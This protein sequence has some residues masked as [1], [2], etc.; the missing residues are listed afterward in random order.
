VQLENLFKILLALIGIIHQD[1][2]KAYLSFEYD[3]DFLNSGIEV[4]LFVCHGK[5]A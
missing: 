4:Y 2:T 3:K 1:L 5:R